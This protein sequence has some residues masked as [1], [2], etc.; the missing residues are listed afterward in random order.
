MG[1]TDLI[2]GLDEDAAASILEN[3]DDDVMEDAIETGIEREVVPHLL[4]V[5]ERADSDEDPDP[6]YVRAK[7]EDLSEEEQ[8]EKF[9]KAAA[10]V[11]GVMA[12]V[13]NSPLSGLRKL[14]GRLRDPWTIEALL[15]IFDHPEIPDDVVQERKN[16]AADWL[17][18]AGVHVIPEVYTKEDAKEVAAVMYPNRDPEAAAEE[19]L[20]DNE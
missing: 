18:Y 14:K 10:D 2:G 11:M 16:Y 12:E 17:K 3:M 5:R 19:L 13:R 4:D 20:N 7:Y 8:T 1:I 9:N 15:L 6:A